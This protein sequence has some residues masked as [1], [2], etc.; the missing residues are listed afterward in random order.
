ME[1]FDLH[2]PTPNIPNKH[3]GNIMWLIMAVILHVGNDCSIVIFKLGSP[4]CPQ[5]IKVI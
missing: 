4:P 1:F 5:I 2:P 3:G